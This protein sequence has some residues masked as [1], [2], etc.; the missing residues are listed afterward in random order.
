M[1]LYCML[2]KKLF[3]TLSFGVFFSNYAAYMN[4]LNTRGISLALPEYMQD[5][6]ALSVYKHYSY[7]PTLEN[8]AQ[9]V[10]SDTMNEACTV[11]KLKNPS[12]HKVL[13]LN[14]IRSFKNYVEKTMFKKV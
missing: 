11:T 3:F 8:Y 10:V 7:Q 12:L 5:R 13:N 6:L 9:K 14:S 2:F 1:R 4:L